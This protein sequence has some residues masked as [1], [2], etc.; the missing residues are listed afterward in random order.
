MNK[1]PS[2]LIIVDIDNNIADNSPRDYLLP[3]QNTPSGQKDS[4]LIEF[5][6]ACDKDIPNK[7]LIEA[8]Q[9][10]YLLSDVKFLFISG[11]KDL[12]EIRNKTISW[13][14][15]QGFHTPEVILRHP[16][17]RS[18]TAYFK[19]SSIEKY[20]NDYTIDSNF[21][22]IVVEDNQS[23]IQKFHTHF[24]NFK[25]IGIH[26]TPELDNSVKAITKIHD[27]FK[28]IFSPDSNKNSNKKSIKP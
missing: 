15:N 18:N 27:T 10:Y 12:A 22:L 21:K 13:L 20:L 11:R 26:V 16:N 7:P 9:E 17:S 1:L 23:V 8:L 2:T 14:E 24:E 28:N 3:T 5:H 4:K 25:V 6:S 19:S